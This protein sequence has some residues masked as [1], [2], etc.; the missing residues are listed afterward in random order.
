MSGMALRSLVDFGRR[1]GPKFLA[2]LLALAVF[3]YARLGAERE[4]RLRVPVEIRNLPSGLVFAGEPPEAVD[5][6][7]RHPAVGQ[8]DSRTARRCTPP[9]NRLC[10]LTN[11]G[12]GKLS[13]SI[14]QAHDRLSV[15]CLELS[16]CYVS[17]Q[18]CSRSRRTWRDT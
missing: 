6:R 7:V 11:F 16:R 5:L 1:L 9:P 10:S 4:W 3:A 2:F 12:D 18:S 15:V 14:E 17:I 8:Y 13:E